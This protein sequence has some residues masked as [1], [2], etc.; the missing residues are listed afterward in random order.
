MLLPD[1]VCFSVS[2]PAQNCHKSS[3]KLFNL[4]FSQ[5]FSFFFDRLPAAQ[6]E[7]IPSTQTTQTVNAFY[8]SFILPL[9]PSS[10]MANSHESY[11]KGIEWH[12]KF[13]NIFEG[14]SYLQSFYRGLNFNT[15]L[16]CIAQLSKCER[17][18]AKHPQHN[19]VWRLVKNNVLCDVSKWT[20]KNQISLKFSL[21]FSWSF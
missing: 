12:G 1:I 11:T 17:L 2:E 3:K 15:V 18:K 7:Q 20:N 5:C 13:T 4:F 14:V 21:K 6:R 19:H 9:Y 10:S 8:C 16:Y